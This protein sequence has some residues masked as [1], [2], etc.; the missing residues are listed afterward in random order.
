[1][2]KRKEIDVNY[3]WDLTPIYK[4]EEEFNKEYKE[5]SAL[6]D[7]FATHKDTMLQTAENLYETITTHNKITRKIT[8][9]YVY[10]NL[11]YDEDTSNNNSASRR[12]KVI[13]L[14]DK[15]ENISYFYVPNI[16]EKEYKD[17]EKM[18]KEYPPLKEYEI[19]L[20]NIFRYKTHTLSKTEENILSTI[21]SLL[22][23]NEDIYELLKESDMEFDNIEIN[24]KKEK[25]NDTNYKI[26]IE[27]P[28]RAIREKA[29]KTLYK[30]YKQFSNTY[31]TT[32]YNHI[33]ENAV[34]S[35]LRKYPSSLESALYPDE[36]TPEIY[37]NLI[38]TIN[39][40]LPTIYKYYQLRKQVLNLDTLHLYDV[41]APLVE[42]YTKKYTFE[43]GKEIV[44]KALEPL[45]SE[46]REILDKA[47]AQKWIDVYP[48]EGKRTGGYS[49]GCYD[50]YPYILLNY[51][52]KYDDVSTLAHELGHS[53]HS[54]YSRT[55]NPYQNSG[56]AIFVAEVASTVNELLLAKYLLKTSTSK[57]EKLYILN[58]LMELF[59]ATIYRQTMFAEFE[60]QAYNLVEKEE[61]LTSE[62]ISNI[63]YD[64]NKKYFGKDTF[65]D[66]EIKYEW[67]RIPH[68]YY[69]FYVYKYATGLSAAVYIVENIISNNQ[70]NKYIDFLKCGITKNPLDSLK[71][72]GVDLSKPKVVEDAIKYFDKV[73]ENFKELQ[74]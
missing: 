29:F 55:T 17:I 58:N 35:K 50:T 65:I 39:K 8:K 20:K 68:F 69:D 46:Y 5:V 7:T 11:I 27:S 9:L 48:N 32:L 10:A 30:T 45:G 44:L 57:E 33:K 40:N 13:N 23:K 14:D 53:V 28:D 2:K 41:Y 37:N 64:L 36:L 1:M 25:L 43:E 4:N 42:K 59:R 63:Y 60:K 31:A 6:V 51:Q 67:A 24:G 70:T 22:G 26:Y 66:E 52:D 15:F 21:S 19:P 74:K 18:Y 3:T 47:F 54:Y 12:G 73:I 16:L 62:K 72:A 34:I 49:G 71:L 38:N 61:V 56:Y